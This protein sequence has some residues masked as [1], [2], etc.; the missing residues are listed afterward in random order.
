M[1]A[2]LLLSECEV[3]AALDE[4]ADAASASHAPREAAQ[5]TL[6]A[7]AAFYRAAPPPAANRSIAQPQAAS[8]TADGAVLTAA[9]VAQRWAA[10]EAAE[11]TCARR[12]AGA[13]RQIGEHAAELRECALA[14]SR[15]ALG[16]RARALA[17]SDLQRQR[18]SASSA[19][20]E[21]K[22]AALQLSLI[23][24]TYDARSMRM[25]E[26]A[27]AELERA[28][29][30]SDA[31]RAAA[32]AALREFD[33]AGMTDVVDEYVGVRRKTREAE[34]QLRQLLDAPAAEE[35][36]SSKVGRRR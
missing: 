23:A 2:P 7:L 10:L 31:E 6:R 36:S 28:L 27:R 26:L 9:A 34:A 11:A 14:A 22:L 20:L 13:D 5:R 19:L 25:L 1:T 16:L 30:D 4:R 15:A 32:V 24:Q 18:L 17:A 8:A 12:R 3:L 35:E 29:A 21:A 33:R